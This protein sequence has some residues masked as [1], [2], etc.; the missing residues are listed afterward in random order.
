MVD[1]YLLSK[2]RTQ[3]M[4]MAALFILICHAP[5]YGVVLPHY[6]RMLFVWGNVGVDIFLFLSGLGC[7]F[8]LSQYKHNVLYWIIKRYKRIAIPYIIIQLLFLLYY[9]CCYDFRME[10]WLLELSTISFWTNHTGCWYIAFLIPVYAIAPFM[11]ACLKTQDKNRHLLF[12]ILLVL[13]LVLVN[14]GNDDLKD[15]TSILYNVKWAFKRLPGFILGVYLA[16]YILS[17]KKISIVIFIGITGLGFLL[18]NTVLSSVYSWWFY[19]P[20]I[21]LLCSYVI[22]SLLRTSVINAVL[23]WMG[24]KLRILCNKHSNKRYHAFSH[25]LS[26]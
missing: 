11:F 1:L 4:G 20:L 3:L 21:C 15:N 19:V 17:R 16:P 2:Y 13:T 24:G 5:A 18:F 14:T 26:L 7:F 8:S 6:I 9:V 12:L 23:T 25:E 22:N 10:S